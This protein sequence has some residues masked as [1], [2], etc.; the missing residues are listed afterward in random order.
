MAPSS[1]PWGLP[2]RPAA[3]AQLSPLHRTRNRQSNGG[4]AVDGYTTSSVGEYFG[5]K[6]FAAQGDASKPS[7]QIRTVD[8][9]TEVDGYTI[10]FVGEYFGGKGLTAG[11]V[12]GT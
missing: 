5:G 9:R 6:A 2:W 10:S 12:T 8:W 3:S 1:S 11:G 4:P 7:N